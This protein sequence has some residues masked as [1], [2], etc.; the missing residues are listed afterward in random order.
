MT[1]P[2]RTPAEALEAAAQWHTKAASNCAFDG[3]YA[4]ADWHFASA[5]CIR[6]LDTRIEPLPDDVAMGR[7]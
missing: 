2:I 4:K 5:A 3:L 7:K 1:H 6:A